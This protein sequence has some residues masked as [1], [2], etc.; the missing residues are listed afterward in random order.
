MSEEDDNPQE[1]VPDFPLNYY[2]AL[3]EETVFQQDGKRGKAFSVE[4]DN[5]IRLKEGYEDKGGGVT[6]KKGFNLYSTLH[7]DR[8]F[9]S[10]RNLAQTL[11]WDIKE[12]EEVEELKAEVQEQSKTI[13]NLKETKRQQEEAL[14]EL[15]RKNI[16]DLIERIEEFEKDVEEF[17][18]KLEESRGIDDIEEEEL[19][20]FLKER[21]WIFGYEYTNSEPQKQAGSMDQ[22]DFYL[23][24][25]NGTSD[26]IEIKKVTDPILKSDG[27]LRA[28]VV[29][30]VDQCIEYLWTTKG[31]SHSTSR[32]RE[33]EVE[34]L[35]PRGKII[36]GNDAS[37]EAKRKID[38]WEYQLNNIEIFTY[39][40]LLNKAETTL[41]NFKEAKE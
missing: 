1:N 6:T 39:Q 34:E 3:D 38:K 28:K 10:L 11:G 40:E 41:E 8:L 18:K 30:A 12:S 25:Y 13:D 37:E 7:V 32:S 14:K 16:Q 20:Q 24:R 4:D 29:Q 33:E 9:N 36:I 22:F 26:I 15:K 17:R 19:Q 23:E 27:Q 5:L 2:D 21:P 35:R 31:I